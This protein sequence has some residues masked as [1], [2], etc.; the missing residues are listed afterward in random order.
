MCLSPPS[1]KPQ[2]VTL[3]AVTRDGVDVPIKG[4]EASFVFYEPPVLSRILGAQEVLPYRRHSPLILQGLFT[5]TKDPILIRLEG[6]DTVSVF[7]AT[8]NTLDRNL[9]ARYEAFSI[10][11]PGLYEVSVALN[12]QQFEK[13]GI[14]LPIHVGHVTVEVDV[15]H[16]CSSVKTYGVS[17]QHVEK[18][19]EEF[20]EVASVP[21]ERVDFLGHRR[22]VGKPRDH[23]WHA[24]MNAET[25]EKT[26]EHG[27]AVF[28]VY[29]HLPNTPSAKDLAQAVVTNILQQDEF[30]RGVPV[31]VRI[32]DEYAD[33]NDMPAYDPAYFKNGQS[34]SDV[35]HADDGPVSDTGKKTTTDKGD[36]VI[37]IGSDDDSS[38]DSESEKS[39][40]GRS[41]I[42]VAKVLV[43]GSLSGFLQ[44]NEKS[45]ATSFAD[46]IKVPAELVEFVG[47][48]TVGESVEFEYH[49]TV[50]D[51][52]KEHTTES[53]S[54][55]LNTLSG[56]SFLKSSISSVSTTFID[57]RDHA[58]RA[59]TGAVGQTSSSTAAEM[60]ISPMAYGLP[61]A[62]LV[63][64]VLVLVIVGLII[65]KPMIRRTIPTSESI[66]KEPTGA[67]SA[68][69]SRSGSMTN[70][71]PHISLSRTP[72][73][74]S[75][76][77]ILSRSPSMAPAS[78]SSGARMGVIKKSTSMVKRSASIKRTHSDEEMKPSLGSDVLDPLLLPSSQAELSSSS[79][80]SIGPPPA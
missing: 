1:D 15:A 26:C 70:M 17:Q 54:S 28:R 22:R 5:H 52:T 48:R 53:L 25:L 29:D 50:P 61:V 67:R 69:V 59:S 10:T 76:S 19:A 63:A 58:T 66:Q 11:R 41:T 8:F 2:E 36:G 9:R 33:S 46:L 16:L 23:S 18:A 39:S 72:S 31:N 57:V 32:H 74:L 62:I 55:A 14:I 45:I 68:S 42:I 51:D 56:A 20:G 40:S 7:P 43:S 49:V 13:T 30:F 78:A 80:R 37:P 65:A 73:S 64:S 44:I 60:P 27:T 4:G 24:K 79:R 34:D 21:L 47:V 71:S 38:K 75:A 35:V 3:S 6:Q 12:G 77:H